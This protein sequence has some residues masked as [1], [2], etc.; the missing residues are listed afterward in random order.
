[1]QCFLL[2]VWRQRRHCCQ[3]TIKLSLIS[4]Q[5]V[6]LTCCNSKAS[7][8]Q[9]KR[10][11][12]GILQIKSKAYKTDFDFPEPSVHW[13]VIGKDFE[14][15]LWGY[16]DW[17]ES[18][19]TIHM[20][21]HACHCCDPN[22]AFNLSFFASTSHGIQASCSSPMQCIC[23][24]AVADFLSCDVEICSAWMVLSMYMPIPKS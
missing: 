20:N 19:I 12:S 5:P 18:F 2:Q 23:R 1:M 11:K 4:T 14:L 17:T 10:D 16:A 3:K 24:S 6:C 13:E 15:G 8:N 9:H 22:H 21:F 7:C